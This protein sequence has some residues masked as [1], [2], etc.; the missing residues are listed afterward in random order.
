[1]HEAEKPRDQ[2]RISLELWLV[3]PPLSFRMLTRHR[4]RCWASWMH[5][6]L[7]DAKT[8]CLAVGFS[9]LYSAKKR[10]NCIEEQNQHQQLMMSDMWALCV[11]GWGVRGGG[12]GA[13]IVEGI[14]NISLCVTVSA[15]SLHLIIKLDLVWLQEGNEPWIS[16]EKISKGI[17]VL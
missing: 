1:M 15:H 9:L 6:S 7:L 12:R 14:T 5:H 10:G 11:G 16:G 13:D 4:Q 8:S 2:H 3:L 17:S